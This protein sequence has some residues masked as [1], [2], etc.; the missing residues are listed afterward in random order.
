MAVAGLNIET[1]M[2]VM[3]ILELKNEEIH[4]SV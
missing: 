1:V 2:I 4:E 3:R